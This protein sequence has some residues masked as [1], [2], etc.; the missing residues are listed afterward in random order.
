[1]RSVSLTYIKQLNQPEDN[2]DSTL[3]VAVF[4]SI[5]RMLLAGA[6]SLRTLIN[7]YRR[8]R[9]VKQNKNHLLGKKS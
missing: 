3:H 8:P 2:L 5:G 9:R 1:M 4:G 7:F 6:R